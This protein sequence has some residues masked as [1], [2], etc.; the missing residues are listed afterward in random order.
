MNL[1]KDIT[2]SQQLSFLVS[3]FRLEYENTMNTLSVSRQGIPHKIRNHFF[4][5]HA[6]L[7]L[8]DQEEKLPDFVSKLSA[9]QTN[10]NNAKARQRT[11]HGKL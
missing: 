10:L 8:M 11:A 9:S 3:W 7:P 2:N 4:P 6:L 5:L 1:P